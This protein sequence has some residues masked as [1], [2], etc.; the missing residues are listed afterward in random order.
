M[1]STTSPCTT[2]RTGAASTPRISSAPIP[3]L[4]A[5]R[6]NRTTPGYGRLF[7]IDHVPAVTFSRVFEMPVSTLPDIRVIFP[8]SIDRWS[9]VAVFFG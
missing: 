5:L 8:A 4:R 1:W 2:L 3:C 7:V 6:V 9:L